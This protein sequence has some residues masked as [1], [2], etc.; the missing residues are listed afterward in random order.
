MARLHLDL[1]EEGFCYATRMSVRSTDVNAGRHLGNDALVSMLSE[2]RS[3]FLYQHGVDDAG[4][5]ERPG[6][7]V[8]DL[9]TLY[10][11]EARS[12]DELLF[13]VGLTDFNKYGADVIFRVSRPAGGQLIA[14][15]KTGFVFFDYRTGK[16]APMPDEF[17]ARFAE[18]PPSV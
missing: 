2:A 17:R 18:Q 4:G 10:K 16:V 9:L 1:P 8:T 13:E 12:R 15:A 6:I 7:V 11:A 3:R 14:L 5:T